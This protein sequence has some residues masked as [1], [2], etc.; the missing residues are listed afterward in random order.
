MRCLSFLHCLMS[1]G[2]KECKSYSVKRIRS[3]IE[4][5]FSELIKLEN[6]LDSNRVFSR[7]L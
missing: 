2:A 6:L 1:L 4:A 5:D 7:M 3:N